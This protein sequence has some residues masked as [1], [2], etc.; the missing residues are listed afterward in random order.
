MREPLVTTPLR[1][2]P[3]RAQ[4]HH[5][6]NPISHCQWIGQE[7]GTSV[8]QVSR[9]LKPGMSRWRFLRERWSSPAPAGC[10]RTLPE[11]FSPSWNSFELQYRAGGNGHGFGLRRVNVNTKV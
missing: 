9:I 2:S 10:Q 8:A 11:R 3:A 6:P 1:L 5:D 4:P 7:E